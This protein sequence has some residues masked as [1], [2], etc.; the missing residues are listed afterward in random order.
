MQTKFAKKFKPGIA[1]FFVVLYLMTLPGKELPQIG[2]LDK[3]YFDKWV[4]VVVFGLLTLLFCWPFYRSSFNR[5]EKLI[6]FIKIAI[7]ASVWG[8][9]IEFIQ[10]FFVAGR[11]FDI[12][13][14]VA[15]SI[16]AIMG[17]LAARKYFS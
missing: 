6:Y 17:Y 11:S 14:W 5:S 4:H 16:G 9:T 13:D 15:D 12:L 10:K 2:W 1:W 8:L 3:I 7:A